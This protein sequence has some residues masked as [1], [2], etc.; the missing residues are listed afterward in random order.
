MMK[1]SFLNIVQRK[2]ITNCDFG[3]L[4]FNR[5]LVTSCEF[6]E[7]FHCFKSRNSNSITKNIMIPRFVTLVCI[8]LLCVSPSIQNFRQQMEQLECI[9]QTR[10]AGAFCTQ[11]ARLAAVTCDSLQVNKADMYKM[12]CGDADYDI[13]FRFMCLNEDIPCT[14][15]H[16]YPPLMN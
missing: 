8:C 11:I 4:D 13:L 15:P 5:A 16:T 3:P 7:L 10:V 12:G 14:P 6:V 2:F 1:S 9:I